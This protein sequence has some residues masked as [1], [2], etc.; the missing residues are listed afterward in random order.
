MDL[1]SLLLARREADPTPSPADP[2]GVERALL[3]GD[4]REAGWIEA[5]ARLVAA[6][7]EAGR[8]AWPLLRRMERALPDLD[9]PRAGRA[10]ASLAAQALLEGDA[11]VFVAHAAGAA[12]AF[13]RA[14]DA[15][16]AC[17]ERAAEG[18][19]RV[20]LGEEA[21]A[22]LAA[23][24]AAADREGLG[25]TAALARRHLARALLRRG[26]PARAEEHA[27]IAAR[28][29]AHGR[30]V[31]AEVLTALGRHDEACAAAF[32][33]HPATTDEAA[34]ALA[35]AALAR[36]LTAMGRAGEAIDVL[37]AARAKEIGWMDGG[38]APVWTA[39]ADART[40][41]GDADGARAALGEAKRAVLAFGFKLR[42]K[43][44]R[45]AYL[46]RIPEHRRALQSG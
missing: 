2:D 44:V 19:G 13:D 15:R 34:R 25:L 45:R 14:G 40:A 11:E 18:A 37:G 35:Q 38:A 23:A 21:E 1:P 24:V 12:A 10:L 32:G 28:S 27:A 17:V 31:L 3:D 33:V 26:E 43:A 42:D 9:P 4:A 30:A 46:E 16:L 7:H 5:A 20:G 6:H 41:A 36:A 39:L 8:D 22:T 29:S